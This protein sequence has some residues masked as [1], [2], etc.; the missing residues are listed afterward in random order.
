M[1]LT[2]YTQCFICI[3]LIDDDDV[4]TLTNIVQNSA[5]ALTPNES[6][7]PSDSFGQFVSSI[8][9]PVYGLTIFKAIACIIMYMYEYYGYTNYGWHT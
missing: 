7:S 4:S 6:A 2:I 8:S 1:Q 3:I 9:I 5:H